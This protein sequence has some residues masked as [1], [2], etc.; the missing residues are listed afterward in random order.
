M[1]HGIAA[2][3]RMTGRPKNCVLSTSAAA[4]PS[5]TAQT[6]VTPVYASV[7]ATDAQNLSLPSRYS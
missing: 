7:V 6:T 3:A 2:T 4:V 1:A 5:P